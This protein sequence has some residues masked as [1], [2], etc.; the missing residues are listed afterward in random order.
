V[1]FGVAVVGSR[2][3][4]VSERERESTAVIGSS[5]TVGGM[6]EVL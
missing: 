4:T 3:G 6:D 1:R 5:A 2:V